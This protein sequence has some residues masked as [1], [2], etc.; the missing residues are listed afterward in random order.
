MFAEPLNRVLRVTGLEACV[1]ELSNR[2]KPF[3]QQRRKPRHRFVGG[4]PKPSQNL[5]PGTTFLTDL[6]GQGLL[7]WFSF[8][9][10]RVG[11]L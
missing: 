6:G 3:L 1:Q 5:F 4:R 2:A 7:L 11:F 9:E 10:S 8:T